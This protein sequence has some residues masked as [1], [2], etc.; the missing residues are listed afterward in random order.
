MADDP[1]TL[2]LRQQLLTA[3]QDR[4]KKAMAGNDPYGDRRRVRDGVL[5]AERAILAIATEAVDPQAYVM[6][7]LDALGREAD[8]LAA[9]DADDEDHW[10][11]GAVRTIA[12]EAKALA[13]MK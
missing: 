10:A 1:K 9:D 11:A 4:Y 13:G 8:R 12:N 5:T 7:V 2:A 6:A 3:C